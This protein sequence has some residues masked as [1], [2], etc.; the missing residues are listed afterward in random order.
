MASFVAGGAPIR[1]PY[2]ILETAKKANTGGTIEKQVAS[3][4]K[5]VVVI[6]P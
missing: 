5:S 6:R 2:V 1:E 3:L 4:F